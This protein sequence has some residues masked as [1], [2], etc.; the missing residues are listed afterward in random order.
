MKLPGVISLRKLLPTC[1][2]PN[3]GFLRADGL[4]VLVVDE[5]ALRGLGPQVVQALLALDRAEVGLHQAVE[6]PRLAE[7]ALV[8]AVGAVEVLQRR[9]RLAVLGLVRL[10]KVVGPEPLVARGA[11]GQ[12]VDE[13][14]EVA[15]GRPHV[16][17][18]DHR[19]VQADDVVA[20]LHHRPPP[21]AADVLLELHA[22]RTVVPRR[23]RAA[24]DLTGREDEAPALGQADDGLDAV[25]GHGNANLQGCRRLAVGGCGTVLDAN[26]PGTVA[27]IR[28][29]ISP[30]SP[31]TSTSPVSTVLRHDEV[32][33]IHGPV[34][35]ADRRRH[36]DVLGEFGVA[37]REVTHARPV[38]V[39]ADELALGRPGPG[40]RRRAGCTPAGT[41]RR[42]PR[43]GTRSPR[44]GLVDGPPGCRAPPDRRSRTSPPMHSSDHEPGGQP[45]GEPAP[46][47]R[48]VRRR[49]HERRLHAGPGRWR[50]YRRAGAAMGSSAVMDAMAIDSVAVVAPAPVRPG[51]AVGERL[52]RRRLRQR[53]G[54]QRRGA[55]LDLVRPQGPAVRP[56]GLPFGH[57]APQVGSV[58]G[59]GEL[60]A[61]GTRAGRPG[62]PAPPARGREELRRRRRRLRTA[63]PPARQ[64]R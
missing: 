53:P 1:A 41:R 14:L 21:L 39:V 42:V 24:V 36:P 44:P 33:G 49:R 9:G 59:P 43:S 28:N 27:G 11:L 2:M 17:G 57:Q 29:E 54:Q 61:T 22:E 31:Q 56:D 34:G 4:H 25:G 51:S 15:R 62:C 64:L 38:E 8:A 30:S 32:D 18:E 6:H 40:A 16:L 48:P 58:V 10:L 46:L 47:P 37:H 26:C 3:G 60:A 12:R 52:E 35:V 5:D 23:P 7:G 19:G 50:R 55:G 63:S 13:G 45:D 20:L